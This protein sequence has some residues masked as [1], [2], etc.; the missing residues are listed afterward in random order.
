ML[1]LLGWQIGGF[2]SYG[3]VEIPFLECVPTARCD[4]LRPKVKPPK[5]GE[6]WVGVRNVH[7][8]TAP[9][10]LPPLKGCERVVG[11]A[12]TFIVDTIWIDSSIY[13][14]PPFSITN[15]L[16]SAQYYGSE[17]VRFYVR[18]EG[19]VALGFGVWLDSIFYVLPPEYNDRYLYGEGLNLIN[20]NFR[21][22]LIPGDRW[23]PRLGP[24]GPG[25]GKRPARPK[26]PK[27]LSVSLRV[28]M[29]HYEGRPLK[30]EVSG[31]CFY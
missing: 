2:I 26:R 6:W 17:G 4:T 7:P 16:D 21:R 5:P 29:T 22:D 27:R 18:A 19:L 3:M 8:D 11:E 14:L 10:N 24:V 31:L 12:R 25:R 1:L 23:P 28:Q 30:V 20:I 13:Y 15:Y 9:P